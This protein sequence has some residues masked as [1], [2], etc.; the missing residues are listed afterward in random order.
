MNKIVILGG[1]GLMGAGIARDLL[2]ERAFI[3]I[4][5]VRICD[6]SFER[7]QK[8]KAELGDARIEL[9]PLD[10]SKAAELAAALEGMQLCIN[11]VP[12]LAGHQMAIFE[13]ALAARVAYID[14]GGLGTWTVRQLAEHARFAAAGVTA[15]IGA[16][17]DPGMSNV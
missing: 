10:V 8:L 7:M 5:C 13:A 1:A 15:V 2:S 3:D 6:S 16:G 9:H 17:A 14:L 12:T 4:G 11:A